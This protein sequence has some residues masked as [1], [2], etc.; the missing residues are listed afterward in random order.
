MTTDIKNWSTTAADNTSLAGV[1]AAEGMA[2]S[3][4]NNLIRGVAAEVRE[5]YEDAEWIDFGDTPTNVDADTF[6]VET[7]LTARY[8]VGRR[9][10]LEDS[11]T[12][13]GTITASSYSSPDTTVDVTLDSGSISAS[14]TAVAVGIIN[15]TNT[16]LAP[17]P[18]NHLSGLTLSNGTDA[19]HDI[20]VAAGKARDSADAVGLFLGGSV[21]KQID[22]TWAAGTNAGGLS[23][24]LTAPANSTWYHV[25]LILVGG[26]VDVGFDTSVTAANLVTDHSATAYRRLGSVLTDGS[27]NVIAFTQNGD[28]FLWKVPRQDVDETAPGTGSVLKTMSAPLGVKTRVISSWTL[29]DSATNR[30]L[31]I[32]SPDQTDTAPTTNLADLI[33][34]AGNT[35]RMFVVRS[36]RTNTSS[37]VR[38]RLAS[39][40][41]ATVVRATTHG[42]LDDLGRYD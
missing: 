40:G 8:T 7:D 22:A 30:Q 20:D 13:Y 42:Y 24:S 14:L 10:K 18:T 28:E 23:S 17:M 2:P 15:P 32:L 6:T 35:D 5:W 38:R 19:D 29:Y 21:T 27:A 33:V 4:V 16:S 3:A 39:S 37:Q 36:V 11:S 1:T 31:F 12:L 34:D 9:V 26:V 41:A 25:H